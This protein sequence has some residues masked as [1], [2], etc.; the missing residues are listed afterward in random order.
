MLKIRRPLGR[1]IFNMGI[2][3]PGKTVF[4]IETAPCWLQTNQVMIFRDVFATPHCSLAVSDAGV[5]ITIHIPGSINSFV[6]CTVLLIQ[7]ETKWPPSH[8]RQHLYLYYWIRMY[9]IKISLKSNSQQARICSYNGLVCLIWTNDCPIHW[10]TRKRT[11]IYA[12]R[13]SRK[14]TLLEYLIS[15]FTY[16]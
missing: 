2:A 15:R 13:D 4:L 6:L 3:I 14:L 5:S 11:H 1:L 12:S 9:L 10:H 7:V 16:V 8:C